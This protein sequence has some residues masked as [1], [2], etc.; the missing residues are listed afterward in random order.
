MWVT[1]VT[2]TNVHTNVCNICNIHT[3]I[4]T[5]SCNIHTN[6]I[7]KLTFSRKID[8]P[9]HGNVFNIVILI[10]TTTIDTYS[11]NKNLKYSTKV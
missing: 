6:C 9:D 11:G 2:H 8:R 10:S 4:H 1:N 5:N 3:N 7:H